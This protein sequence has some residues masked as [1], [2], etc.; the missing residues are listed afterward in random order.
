MK[1]LI[2]AQMGYG[3]IDLIIDGYVHY[4]KEVD[5]GADADNKRGESR[6][7]VDEVTNISAYDNNDEEVKLNDYDKDNAADILARKFLEG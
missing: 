5:Y 7:F 1:E 2:T 4:H 3:S 6:I